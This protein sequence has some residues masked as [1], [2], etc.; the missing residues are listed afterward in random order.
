MCFADANA[1]KSCPI[2][3]SQF[4]ARCFLFYLFLYSTWIQAA[5]VELHLF[6]FFFFF[7]FFFLCCCCFLFASSGLLLLTAMATV[8]LSRHQLIINRVAFVYEQV[9][10]FFLLGFS[11]FRDA[12]R[13]AFKIDAGSFSSSIDS[14]PRRSVSSSAG[15][16]NQPFSF[17]IETEK[18]LID[19]KIWPMDAEVTHAIVSSCVIRSVQ[20]YHSVPPR[21][22]AIQSNLIQS[23]SIPIYRI[24]WASFTFHLHRLF[25][26]DI[27]QTALMALMVNSLSFFFFFFLSC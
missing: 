23:N 8:A 7:F 18:R 3:T 14:W 20:I 25:G 5:S 10:Y 27:L 9:S 24:Q 16:A 6:L 26:L 1:R 11:L 15:G 2:E 21:P 4:A 17:V 12:P 13:C 19:R 22:A